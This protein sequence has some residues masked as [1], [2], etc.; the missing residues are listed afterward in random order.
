MRKITKAKGEGQGHCHRCT[1]MGK[2][3]RT[4]MT[5]LCEVEGFSGYY[6]YECANILANS[7][8]K[9]DALMRQT[10]IDR[11]FYLLAETAYLIFK[12][13]FKQ[14]NDNIQHTEEALTY[15]LIFD[16]IEPETINLLR[17]L[18]NQLEEVNDKRWLMYL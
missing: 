9:E 15:R 1:A 16:M 3:N 11:I 10:Y 14:A 2:W 17:A 8:I 7:T 4:W 13:D 18:N 12:E 6:C 5:F